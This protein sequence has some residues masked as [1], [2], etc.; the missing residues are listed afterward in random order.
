MH[1]VCFCQD[2]EYYESDTSEKIPNAGADD[3]SA[4]VGDGTAEYEA[5]GDD[6]V[7][8]EYAVNDY[9][10]PVEDAGAADN[11]AAASAA[12][13]Q[14]TVAQITD[15]D[16]EAQQQVEEQHTEHVE[17]PVPDVPDVRS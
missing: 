12:N 5:A 17:E 9:D 1:A 3:Y 11:A 7:E 13:V 10:K 6:N 14:N 8:N 16:E 4:D 15:S 2:E